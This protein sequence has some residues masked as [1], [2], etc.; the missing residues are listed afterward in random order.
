MRDTR[1]GKF[2]IPLDQINDTPKVALAILAGCIVVRAESMWHSNQIEYI[3]V[4]DAF[5]VVPV[6]NVP[7]RY[8]VIV[9]DLVGGNYHVRF[10]KSALSH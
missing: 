7:P 3:A 1:I 2:S 5:D 9:Q 4:N 10:V 8:D 6:G